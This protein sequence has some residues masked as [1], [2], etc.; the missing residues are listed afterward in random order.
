MKCQRCKAPI[1]KDLEKYIGAKTVCERCFYKLRKNG[2]N[3]SPQQRYY[4][5]V[6]G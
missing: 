5:W 1:P 3:E 6:V 4:N 2:G